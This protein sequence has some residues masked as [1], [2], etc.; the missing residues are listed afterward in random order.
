[1]I[2]IAADPELGVKLAGLLEEQ[3]A[4]ERAYAFSLNAARK[5]AV[6]RAH[7]LLLVLLDVRLGG[8]I[9]RA[10]EHVPM[11]GRLSGAPVVVVTRSP[12]PAEIA[13]MNQLGAYTWLDRC[14]PAIGGR[15]GEIIAV[16]RTAARRLQRR[17]LRPR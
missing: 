4:R 14:S 2:L 9:E 13:E 11:L 6:A 8:N 7:Q 12:G 10:V 15:L 1:L 17:A 16:R 5:V 3:G